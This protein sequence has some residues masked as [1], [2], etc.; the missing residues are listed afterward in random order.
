MRKF[1]AKASEFIARLVV[2][3][4]TASRRIGEIEQLHNFG[5]NCCR[6][7]FHRRRRDIIVCVGM[8]HNH[9][10]CQYIT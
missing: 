10:M 9:N 6:K 2:A 5:I 4:P 1:H 8:I 3:S 7:H